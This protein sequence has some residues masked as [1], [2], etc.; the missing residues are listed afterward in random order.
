[1]PDA[2]SFEVV[3][4]RDSTE[5]GIC[6]ARFLE[7]AFTTVEF[8]IKVTVSA[9]GTWSYDKDTVLMVR[10]RA[11]PFHHTDSN[12]LTRVGDPTPNP[13]ASPRL[14]V[15]RPQATKNGERGCPESRAAIGAGAATDAG[16]K[17]RLFSTLAALGC[18][19]IN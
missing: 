17:S 2:R 8:R 19:M 5:N 7:F 16:R 9:D 15:S 10:G 6:S 13:L 14:P 1:V 11:E 12:T 18:A 3:A 4:T